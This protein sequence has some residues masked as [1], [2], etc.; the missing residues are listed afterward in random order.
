MM[1]AVGGTWANP[2]L[3]LSLRVAPPGTPPSRVASA[4]GTTTTTPSPAVRAAA[5]AQSSTLR[6]PSN[7]YCLGPPKRVPEPPATTTVQT[8]S[9]LSVAFG[10][11]C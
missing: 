9:T 11:G 2:A 3:T 10:S 8:L 6:V 1:V 5:T 7:S 4:C